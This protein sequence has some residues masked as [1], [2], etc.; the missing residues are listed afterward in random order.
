MKRCWKV[1][2]AI[3]LC[4][5]LLVGCGGNGN[6]GN[7]GGNNANNTG[8]EKNE[9]VKT[10]GK[11]LEGEVYVLA[12]ASLTDAM[13]ELIELYNEGQPNVKVNPSYASS[14]ALQSQIE[15]GAPGDIFLSAAEKQMNALEEQDL[16]DK[17][18]R[19]DLLLNEVVLITPK[20][21]SAKVTGFE[22]IAN[23][24][25]SKIAIADPASVPVGQYSEEI[26]TN[27]GNW[28][29]VKEKMVMSQD[30]RNSLDWVANGEVDCGTVYKTDAYT[31][32]DKV[33]I[34]AS[35]PEGTHKPVQYPMAMIGD[36]ASKEEA[37]DFYDFLLTDEAKAVFEK[38]GFNVN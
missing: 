38:Y 33:E 20:D 6:N 25:V 37:K 26:F 28:D 15:E 9:A 17:E 23:D 29:A 14:G 3:G 13:N 18:T 32:K 4:A 2:L 16:I 30:V 36:S 1:L 19:V 27:L 31:E 22:D 10:E 35:A 11:E 5:A 12:A 8:N 34:V 24:T 7:N 21:T